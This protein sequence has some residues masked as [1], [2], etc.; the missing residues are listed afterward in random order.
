MHGLLQAFSRTNRILNSV[1]AAGNV[2]CFRNIQTRV[3]DAI[4]LFGDKDAGGI[5]L[6]HTFNDY[7][8]GY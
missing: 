5:V 6:L 7:Y 3:D 4:A 1:K 8:Y 2:V